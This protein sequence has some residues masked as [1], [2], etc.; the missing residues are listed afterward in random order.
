[1]RIKTLVLTAAAATLIIGCS[2]AGKA[3]D[4]TSA[5]AATS[6][7][8][9]AAPKAKPKLMDGASA[10]MLAAT[11]AGCHGTNGAST[12]P[13]TPTIA[14]LEEEYFVD[15]MK[16]FKS[17]E[18]YS[19]I[20]QRIAKGY[21]D[22]EIA[23]MAGY[24]SRLPFKPALSQ[25]ARSETGAKLH[26]EYCE[27]CHEDGGTDLEGIVLAGQWVPYLNWTLWDF[28]N[29]VSQINS[30]KMKKRFDKMIAEHGK[31]SLTELVAFY[32]SRSK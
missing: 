6:A 13:A 17:G 23:A 8:A 2:T 11:C 19:T 1:M 10:E 20:M 25:T 27:K 24:F 7:A 28:A 18:R 12:G 16:E 22:E 15:V 3:V 29:G 31:K 14:G 32:G 9:K 4:D 21:S 30:K 5:K 26:D